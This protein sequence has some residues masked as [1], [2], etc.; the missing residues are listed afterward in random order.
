[1]AE[2]TKAADCKSV[3]NTHVGSNPTFLIYANVKSYVKVKFIQEKINA[4]ANKIDAKLPINGQNKNVSKKKLLQI[5]RV[6]R[7]Y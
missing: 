5:S 7:C 2:W 6:F 1:M 4:F 3:G